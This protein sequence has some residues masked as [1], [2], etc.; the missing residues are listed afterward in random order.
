ML[1]LGLVSDKGLHWVDWYSRSSA[2]V[3]VDIEVSE[4]NE[5]I[6]WIILFIEY[7]MFCG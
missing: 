6:S 2:V 3:V 7:I 4:V 1:I 5:D